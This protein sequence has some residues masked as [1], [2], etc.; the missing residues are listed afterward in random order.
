MCQSER[1]ISHLLISFFLLCT[2]NIPFILSILYT[3][4]CGFVYTNIFIDSRPFFS[5]VDTVF[6]RIGKWAKLVNNNVY[7]YFFFLNSNNYLICFICSLCFL[8]IFVFFFFEFY[9]ISICFM[10]VCVWFV[11]FFSFFF[12]FLYFLVWRRKMYGKQTIYGYE[13]YFLK[14]VSVYLL[15]R[16]ICV[17]LFVCYY[18]F[19]L[20]S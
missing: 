14:D 7:V 10:C 13:K 15:V 6:A 12:N 11:F 4:Q 19:F 18:F 3:I 8:F 1:K 17:C 5:F 16:Y 9:F 2:N 20:Y